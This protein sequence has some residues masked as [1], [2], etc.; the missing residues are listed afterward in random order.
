MER[1]E[2]PN[3]AI[4]REVQGNMLQTLP[5]TRRKRH[6]PSQLHTEHNMREQNSEKD[7][8]ICQY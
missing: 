5:K 1:I 7:V 8:N 6:T 3:L 4:C 2:P